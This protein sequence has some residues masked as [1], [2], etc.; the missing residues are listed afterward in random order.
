MITR[1]QKVIG[2]TTILIVS[3]LIAYLSAAAFAANA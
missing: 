3:A 1:A 2:G